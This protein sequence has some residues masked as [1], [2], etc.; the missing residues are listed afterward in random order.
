VVSTP[1]FERK[2]VASPLN[3]E[4]ARILNER[5]ADSS[6]GTIETSEIAK[7]PPIRNAEIFTEFSPSH[8]GY[9]M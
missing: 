6:I 1:T 4:L 2:L 9:W 8:A 5:N 3:V 7:K